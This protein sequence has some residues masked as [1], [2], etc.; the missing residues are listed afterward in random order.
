MQRSRLPARAFPLLAH[1]LPVPLQLFPNWFPILRRRFHDYFL[2][3]LLEQPC[4]QRAQL[5]GV[6]TKHPPFKPELTVNFHV[7]YDYGEHLLVDIDSRYSVGHQLPPGRERR[8][9]CGYLKLGRG[10]SP[11]PQGRQRRPII[12]SN[13]H[14]PDQTES[15]PRLLQC[16][17]DLASPGRRK[18]YLGVIFI[19]FRGPEAL[20]D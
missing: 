16:R 20:K 14:A 13:T 5:L 17:F 9:C 12:R 2:D 11:L 1:R 6:A 15:Q 8:A 18:S 10:L 7:R 3:L 19:T 4:S